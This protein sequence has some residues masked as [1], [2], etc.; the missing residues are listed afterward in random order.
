MTNSKTT[1]GA[2]P[3]KS[4][5]RALRHLLPTEITRDAAF[6]FRQAGTDK[7]H[8]R[9]LV[10]TLR[11]VGDLD[12]VLVWQE[13]DEN[14]KPT[15]RFILLD[16]LHRLAAYATAKGHRQAVP[17]VV[18]QGDRTAAMLEAVKANTRESLPLTKTERTD[19]AWRL[20]RLPGKRLSV[21]TVAKAA[22][23]GAATVDRMRKRWAIMQAAKKEAQGAWWRDRH[24]E[25]PEMKDRPEMTDAQRNAAIEQLSKRLKEALGKMPW[26]DQDIAAEALLRA[27]G[28]HK[29]RTMAE[30]LFTA[31]EFANGGDEGSFG[32][33][34]QEA[35]T[36][37]SGEAF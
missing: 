13:V 25:L 5:T 36:D 4:Q 15:E 35:A 23:V 6:Q 27:V 12:P 29:L 10:Q 1:S 17:A 22:G 2:Q 3:D 34:L 8:L 30:W 28:T 9:G 20:V 37:T 24:D 31:D 33:T 7:A 32:G 21:S 18:I 14:G 19:A 16:G 26:Q 11:T